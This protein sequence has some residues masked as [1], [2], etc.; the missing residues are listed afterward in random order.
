MIGAL[1]AAAFLFGMI[2]GWAVIPAL[3]V[4]ALILWFAEQFAWPVLLLALLAAALGTVRAT[5]N[6]VTLEP[7]TTAF[8]SQHVLVADAV[9]DNGRRQSTTIETDDGERLCVGTFA[10]TDIGRGDRLEASFE[11]I[12][13]QN[14]DRGTTAWLTSRGCSWGGELS[15]ITILHQGSGFLRRVDDIR[16]SI[17]RQF[18]EWFPGDRGALLAGLVIG[19]DSMLSREAREEFRETGTLH[20]VAISGT[21]L[22]LLVALLLP[23]FTFLPRRWMNEVIALMIVWC[24]VLIGGARPPTFRAGALATAAWGGRMLGRPVDLLTLSIQIAAIQ[25]AIFPEN[26]GGLSFQLSTVAILVVVVTVAGRDHTSFWSVLILAVITTA[27][28]QT[29]LLPLLPPD[30]R[31]NILIAVAANVLIAPFIT[32]AFVLGILATLVG[33]IVP[34]LGEA[35]AEVGAIFSGYCLDIVHWLAGAPVPGFGGGPAVPEWLVIAIALG[36]LAAVSKEFRRWLGDLNAA[37]LMDRSYMAP[38]IAGIGFGALAG[39]IA[40]AILM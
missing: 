18:V 4:V 6:L 17:T 33:W 26:L 38:L 22:T 11:P 10:R 2:F 29:A 23:L 19:D 7:Q 34:V 3:A 14:A 28:V 30:N 40:L 5:D 36:L 21:N 31:P 27:A 37:L 24:Y 16:Q 39:T 12:S 9:V 25:V 15:G 13:P 8:T 20:V 1:I 35:I 32:L